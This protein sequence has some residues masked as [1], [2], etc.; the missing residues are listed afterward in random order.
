MLVNFT[1]NEKKVL[2]IL[3]K[4]FSKYYNSNSLSKKLGISRVGTM[5]IL[6][7]FENNDVLKKEIIGKSIIYKINLENDYVRDVISFLLSDEANNFKRWKNEFNEIFKSD[8]V[9]IIYGSAIIN[10]AKAND[11][12]LMI[13]GNS[14]GANK[15]IVEKQKIL[16]KKIH[17]IELSEKEFLSNMKNKQKSIIEIVR[18]GI[19][20]YGQSKYVRVIKNVSRF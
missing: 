16:P 5:K 19:I 20:L 12:D 11:I 3:F 13:V 15:A 4:D 9:V 8:R 6:R 7:K 17:L 14:S 10:Y 2:L 1:L 18:T